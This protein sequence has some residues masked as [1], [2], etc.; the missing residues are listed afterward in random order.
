MTETPFTRK[1]V[2]LLTGELA[3]FEAQEEAAIVAY[4]EGIANEAEDLVHPIQFGLNP[5]YEM[6]L[7]NLQRISF[8]VADNPFQK[9]DS[10]RFYPE[11]H[12]VSAKGELLSTIGPDHRQDKRF[13][14]SEY[15]ENFRDDKLKINDDRKVKLTLSDFNEQDTMLFLT[16]RS[17]GGKFDAAAYSNAWFR[18]QNEDT[19]QSIDYTYIRKVREAESIED[20]AQGGAPADE[21]NEDGDNKEA[22][23]RNEN[24]FLAGRIYREEV[25]NKVKGDP[26]TKNRRLGGVGFRWVYER[27]N[28]VVNSAKFENG[29]G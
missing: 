18:L 8:A 13:S 22:S 15:C 27:Y 19:N 5:F 12:I 23:A 21:D 17:F 2:K 1:F 6:E 9:T 25:Q 24:I 10:N 29:I 7:F 16:V 11:I 28:K 4:A 20:D 14:A 3:E 26:S